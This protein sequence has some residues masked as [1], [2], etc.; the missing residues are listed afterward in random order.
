MKKNRWILFFLFFG[1]AYA[2]DNP[3]SGEQNVS[4]ITPSSFTRSDVK[5]NSNARILKSVSFN[6]INLDGTEET[7]V[8]D[9]N[10]SIDWHDTYT[11][12]RSKSP[13]PSKILDVSVT[14]PSKGNAD[15][16]LSIDVELP[17]QSGSIDRL[18]TYSVYKNKIRLNANDELVSDFSIGNPS[19]IVMD[20]KS[21]V[22]SPSKVVRIKNSFFKRL[23]FG[24]HKGYYRLVLYLDGKYNYKIEKDASGY[25]I[26]IL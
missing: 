16:N 6:Y 25:T 11:I 14:I 19:K 17:I 18:L 21:N 12:M 7:L 5:F 9:V 1:F 4:I 20:F 22:I 23:D 15:S 13:E 26:F 2:N 3:F 8:L 24:S 10:K